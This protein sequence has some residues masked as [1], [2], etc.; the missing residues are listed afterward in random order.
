MIA[1]TLRFSKNDTCESAL[2][3]AAAWYD[4]IADDKQAEFAIAVSKADMACEDVMAAIDQGRLMAAEGRAPFLAQVAEVLD[5][6]IA[7]RRSH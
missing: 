2:R 1:P 6:I 4:R 3:K 7:A 5:S